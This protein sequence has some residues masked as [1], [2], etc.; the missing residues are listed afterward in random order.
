MTLEIEYERPYQGKGHENLQNNI[1]KSVRYNIEWKY[2]DK[3]LI[4]FYIYT[5]KS[6]CLIQLN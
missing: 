6:W 5:Q 1:I 3:C 4:V 2:P